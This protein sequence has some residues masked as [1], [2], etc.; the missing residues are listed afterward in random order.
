MGLRKKLSSLVKKWASFKS[1]ERYAVEFLGE[2]PDLETI[3]FQFADGL[4]ALDVPRHAIAVGASNS[5]P[6]R[7]I[8]EQESTSTRQVKQPK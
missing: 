5:F 1:G 3:S 4:C 2:G 7:G 8:R 6:V